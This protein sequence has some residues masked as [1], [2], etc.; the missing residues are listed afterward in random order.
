MAS[1]VQDQAIFG[2]DGVQEIGAEA[3]ANPDHAYEVARRG[4]VRDL[5]G[6]ELHGAEEP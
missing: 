5:G 1:V 4:V 6:W 2:V 3:D